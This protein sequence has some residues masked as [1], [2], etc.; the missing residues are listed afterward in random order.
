MTKTAWLAIDSGI[1]DFKNSH[2]LTQNAQFRT[3]E[4]HSGLQ[5]L[6]IFSP[7]KMVKGPKETEDS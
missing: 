2:C 3:C 1:V 5:M 7:V 6:A 4:S